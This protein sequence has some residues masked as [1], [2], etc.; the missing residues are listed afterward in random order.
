MMSNSYTKFVINNFKNYKNF[1]IIKI[2]IKRTISVKKSTRGIKY[3][4]LIINY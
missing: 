1:K 3:E 2:P 4:S